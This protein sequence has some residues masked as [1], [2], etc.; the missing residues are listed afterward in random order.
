MIII[1]FI[2]YRCEAI[3]FR[4]ENNTCFFVDQRVNSTVVA[5]TGYVYSDIG[6]WN[7]V[8]EVLVLINW[9]FLNDILCLI[10]WG[11]LKRKYSDNIIS[12]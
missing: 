8:C 1:I 9:F 10:N 12:N 5:D 6:N 4:S 3:N 7:T 11:F 2:L